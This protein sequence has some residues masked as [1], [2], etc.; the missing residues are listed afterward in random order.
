MTREF[1]EYTKSLGNDLSTPNQYFP[2][3][4]PGDSWCLCSSRWEQA[5]RAGKAPRVKLEATNEVALRSGISVETLQLHVAP[6]NNQASDG[7][8]RRDSCSSDGEICER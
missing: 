8:E 6:N 7:E 5:R 3:L 2:G 4:K 1:L